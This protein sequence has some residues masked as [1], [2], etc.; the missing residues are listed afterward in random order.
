[1]RDLSD[2]PLM[3]RSR[4]AWF[5]R[6]HGETPQHLTFGRKNRRGPARLQ[7]MRQSQI[8]IPVPQRVRG[9]VA[10]NDRLPE[11][12]GPPAR[13]RFRADGAAVKGT[14]VAGRKTGSSAV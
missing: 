4:T 1:M 5:A 8:A 12:G 13:T 9:D 7:P 6:K 10:D 11:V 14:C 3:L 2:N